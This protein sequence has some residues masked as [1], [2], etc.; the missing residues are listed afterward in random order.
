M[1]GFVAALLAFTVVAVIALVIFAAYYV[2][3]SF[4]FKKL[5]EKDGSKW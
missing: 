2:F 5:F 1:E 3:M 4:V